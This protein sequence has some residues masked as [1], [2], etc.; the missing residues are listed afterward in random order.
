MLTLVLTL[1]TPTTTITLYLKVLS[2]DI[3]II[4]LI[5]HLRSMRGLRLGAQELTLASLETSFSSR[6][7]LFVQSQ[8]LVLELFD[9]LLQL[10]L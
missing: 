9:G 10:S 5:L 7:I 1:L 4:V 2:N 8:L 6:S 3:L